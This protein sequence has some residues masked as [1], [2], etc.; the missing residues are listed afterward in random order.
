[1]VGLIDNTIH[2]PAP[3]SQRRQRPT[4]KEHAGNPHL[5]PN[6]MKE[7]KSQRTPNWAVRCLSVPGP[8]TDLT[9]HVSFD[10][11][12]FVIGCGEGTQRA[13]A[14]KQRQLKGIQAVLLPN[15]QAKTRAGLPGEL[16]ASFRPI[17]TEQSVQESP[18]RRS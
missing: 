3:I 12:R 4:L 7:R 6:V 15:A 2:H 1:M 11:E 9:L 10:S 5:Q 16:R 14:Q 8:D 17:P 18:V 13:F